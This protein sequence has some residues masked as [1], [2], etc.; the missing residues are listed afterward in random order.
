ML[1]LNIIVLIHCRRK[2]IDLEL[3]GHSHTR[4]INIDNSSLA[5]GQQILRPA[6][7]DNPTKHMT[8]ALQHQPSKHLQRIRTRHTEATRITCE[9]GTPPWRSMDRPSPRA[10]TK[11]I[12]ALVSLHH[13]P[14]DVLCDRY[15]VPSSPIHPLGDYEVMKDAVRRC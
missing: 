2:R 3:A 14:L 11:A 8:R 1:S 13:D 10:P 5:T 15:D 6:N 4:L 12:P 9:C 7:T